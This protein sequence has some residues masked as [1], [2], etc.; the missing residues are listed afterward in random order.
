M[1]CTQPNLAL[2]CSQISQLL[3]NPGRTHLASFWRVLKFLQRTS[4]FTITFQCPTAGKIS[5]ETGKT[6][7][8]NIFNIDWAGDPVSQRSTTRYAFF[9]YERAISQMCWK[10]PTVSLLST[11]ADYKATLVAC[12]EGTCQ[13]DHAKKFT[14]FH[15]LFLCNGPSALNCEMGWWNA[16]LQLRVGPASLPPLYYIGG[17]EHGYSL[18]SHPP[19]TVEGGIQAESPL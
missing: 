12:M 9:L 10:Q 18:A 1:Q 4:K 14:T 8:Q 11:K 5:I 15:I 16:C 2:S 17:V 19:S 6:F 3:D 7:Q 13:R